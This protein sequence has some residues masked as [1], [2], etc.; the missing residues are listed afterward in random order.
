ML[1]CSFMMFMI[2][3]QI[4]LP[5]GASFS[6]KMDF[7]ILL[8]VLIYGPSC[9]GQGDMSLPPL[10]LVTSCTVALSPI[11]VIRAD[12]NLNVVFSRMAVPPRGTVE[13]ER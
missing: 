11:V 7:E 8:V 2:T 3:E 5:V 4:Y 12:Y 13:G 9:G 1:P 10:L 6:Y